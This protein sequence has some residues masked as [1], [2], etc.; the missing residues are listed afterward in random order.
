MDCSDFVELIAQ[1]LDGLLPQS[2][3][4]L[5]EEH[6]SECRR[7]RA[8]LLL[9]K[10]LQDVLTENVDSGLPADFTQRVTESVLE[11]AQAVRRFR[12]WPYLVPA[13][14]LAV[15][16][17]LFW[18]TGADLFDSLSSVTQPLTETVS[19]GI[20]QAESAV[21]EALT[22]AGSE[23]NERASLLPQ[24]PQPMLNSLLVSLVAVLSTIMGLYK[25]FAFLRD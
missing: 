16:T 11:G 2:K 15:V 20:A 3:I 5:L 13:A 8:E 22:R 10:K 19:G 6:L 7:C 25:V 23:L 24:L 18:L 14:A 17:F 9:Q 1:K 21:N 12:R 4:S